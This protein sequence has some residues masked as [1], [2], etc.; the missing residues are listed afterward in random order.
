MFDD[1]NQLPKARSISHLRT[2]ARHPQE[3]F[4]RRRNLS[5]LPLDIS[6]ATTRDSPVGALPVAH[7]FAFAGTTVAHRDA[8]T[9]Q[10]GQQPQG[11]TTL[12]RSTSNQLES[13]ALEPSKV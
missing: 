3:P 13:R 7:F 4:L 12:E 11:N 5:R 9:S 6:D 1:R 8:W 10:E 2:R